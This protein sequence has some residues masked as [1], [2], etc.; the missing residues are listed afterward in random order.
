MK[1][2]HYN[3]EGAPVTQCSDEGSCSVISCEVCLKEIPADAVKV[4]DAQ[5]YVHYFCGLDCLDA[6]QKQAGIREQAGPEKRPD[7]LK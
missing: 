7:Q 1:A 4:K 5:D 6:W 3:P 2:R